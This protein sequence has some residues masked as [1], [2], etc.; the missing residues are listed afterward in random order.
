MNHSRGSANIRFTSS[1]YSEMMA[2]AVGL[3]SVDRRE[4]SAGPEPDSA[5][6][7]N[8]LKSVVLH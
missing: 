3:F 5:R 7:G 8:L 4:F 1:S 2:V 6:Y